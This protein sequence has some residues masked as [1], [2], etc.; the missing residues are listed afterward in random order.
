MK[1][2]LSATQA[3]TDAAGQLRGIA[4]AIFKRKKTKKEATTEARRKRRENVVVQPQQSFLDTS[5]TVATLLF[6]AIWACIV[7][8]CFVGL[9]PAG[10]QIL[11]NRMAKFRVV[12]DFPFTYESSL[13][14]E[15]LVEQRRQ[16]VAPYYQIRMEPFQA[17]N[18]KI[19]ELRT[20][21]ET[22]LW[23]ELESSPSSSW[24]E[25][26]D[27]FNR[28][29]VADL[30][31]MVNSEDLL[32]IMERTTPEQRQRLFE[33][34]S[35][36]LRDIL[37]EGVYDP[38][39]TPFADVSSGY[40]PVQVLGLG[41]GQ[42]ALPE[43]EAVPLLRINL[44]GLG[45]DTSLSRA[46]YRIYRRGLAPNLV[47]DSER[48]EAEKREAAQS[49]RPVQVNISEGQTLIEPGSIITPDQIEAYTA[50]RGEM[51]ERSDYGWGID[52]TL[53][54]RAVLALGLMLGALIYIQVSLRTMH[55]SNRRLA[56]AALVVLFNLTLARLVLQLGESRLIGSD[57]SFLA[58]LPVS[59]PVALGGLIM[60][61]MVG[62]TAGVLVAVFVSAL[63]GLM[64]ANSIDVFIVSLL[65]NLVGIYFGK[66]IRLRAKVVKAATMS[67]LTIAIA[68]LF[69]GFFSGVD[70]VTITQQVVAAAAVGV[71][72]GIV[73]IGVLPLLENIF[74]YT[75]DITLLELTDFNHPLLRKLQLVAPGTYH[76][77]LMVAN[78]AERAASEIGANPLLCRATCLFHDIG[79]MSKPEYFVENQQPGFNPHDEKNPSMS[80]LIIKNHVKEGVQMAREAKLPKVCIDIIEQH[81][82]TTLIKFFY[83]KAIDASAQQ[84]LPLGTGN[85]K[86]GLIDN[87]K[88]D[89]SIFRYDGP[90]PRFKESA[91]IFFADPIEAASRSLKK[92][93]PQ[94]VNELIDNIINDRIE[95]DQLAEAPLTMQEMTVIRE[96]FSF[97][98]MNMLHSRVEYPKS[99]Q[100]KKRSPN[101]P[102]PHPGKMA[103]DAAKNPPQQ[104]SV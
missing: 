12:A 68:T 20:I 74:K 99:E 65:A 83:H 94:S 37:R 62:P 97:T 13:R 21:I 28:R 23:P 40:R 58:I 7:L 43:E 90:R 46:L 55:R 61:I 73:V 41:G 76:H 63:N 79:K 101:T 16:S 84:T 56:L 104:P 96:S 31:L 103:P 53:A 44:A 48:T 64:Q 15:R 86:S 75:T 80:A 35:M 89:E 10:P 4:M 77:S 39:E 66:D 52:A 69:S 18:K 100:E 85:T 67:G 50:Y 78:L 6:L 92:V 24:P 95:D 51:A 57:P 14:T 8:I 1:R 42:R 33:E 30:G 70:P 71:L 5:K 22:Q 91:I 25:L 81:H 9:S 87:S 60:A 2:A 102:S 82:G 54:E 29:Q 98:L 3:G 47:Y 36:V 45:I 11:P 49:V 19:I 26:V 88:I 72:T 34:A 32:I 27:R 38:S 17:F 59:V 93:T